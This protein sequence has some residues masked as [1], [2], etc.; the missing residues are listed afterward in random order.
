MFVKKDPAYPK[1]YCP[2]TAKN[3]IYTVY[4]KQEPKN[5][6]EDESST[7]LSAW[8]LGTTG[9]TSLPGNNQNSLR[10]ELAKEG[11]SIALDNQGSTK[12]IPSLWE[13]V[14]PDQEFPD[15]GCTKMVRKKLSMRWVP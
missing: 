6:Q 14:V 7:V 9:T 13:R 3:A 10:K 8:P 2:P 12:A 5:V 4:T 15:I 1:K 11:D